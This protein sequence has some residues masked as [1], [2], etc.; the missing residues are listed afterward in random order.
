MNKNDTKSEMAE[1][2]FVRTFRDNDSGDVFRFPIVGF[3]PNNIEA[4]TAW[5]KN[6]L[7]P[8]LYKVSSIIPN[9]TYYGIPRIVID[10]PVLPYNIEDPGPKSDRIVILPYS[11]DGTD[12][13]TGV[14][15]EGMLVQMKTS[16]LF[17]KNLFTEVHDRPEDPSIDW[18]TGLR[19]NLT[20]FVNIKDDFPSEED[21]NAIVF[22][23]ENKLETLQTIDKT[24]ENEGFLHVDWPYYA[25]DAVTQINIAFISEPKLYIRNVVSEKELAGNCVQYY[26]VGELHQKLS[27]DGR[28]HKI[29]VYPIYRDARSLSSVFT[30]IPNKYAYLHNWNTD[31]DDVLYD[32]HIKEV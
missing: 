13:C 8:C 16:D 28:K 11:M 6:V 27:A 23:K 15:E 18:S 31:V 32:T 7:Q 4:V 19:N 5:F 30:L 20:K 2:A 17:N 22:C 14:N 9:Q 12:C 21:R 26:V 10:F 3:L 1:Q 29:I 24:L 25:K